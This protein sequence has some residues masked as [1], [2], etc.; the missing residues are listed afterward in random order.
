MLAFEGVVLPSPSPRTVLRVAFE[1]RLIDDGEGWMR[2]LDDRNKMSNTY[3]LR[4][5]E[6]V[7]GAIRATYLGL[8]D[9]LYDGLAA[10]R[11]RDADA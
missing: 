9:E 7:I 11:L 6:Q 8:F 5:F 4:V 10:K 1:H 2:S 3:D